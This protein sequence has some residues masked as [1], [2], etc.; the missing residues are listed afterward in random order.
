MLLEWGLWSSA[1]PR[2]CR[3]SVARAAGR[4]TGRWSIETQS[5][6]RLDARPA[7]TV[8][9]HR[10]SVE[11]GHLPPGRIPR[12]RSACR[13]T[14][15]SP[16]VVR[17]VRSADCSSHSVRVSQ[18]EWFHRETAIAAEAQTWHHPAGTRRRRWLRHRLAP[19]PS[20][21]FETRS[22][23]LA[24]ARFSSPIGQ[25]QRERRIACRP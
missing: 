10:T 2:H 21:C 7:A 18:A 13:R 16:P 25:R 11:T 14:H 17:R 1:P 20:R 15:R 12:C 6:Y 5:G 4:A 3:P 22:R 24:L 19:L 9:R 8:P 23:A